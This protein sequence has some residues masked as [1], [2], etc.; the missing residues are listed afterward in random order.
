[1]AAA[2]PPLVIV[3][4]GVAFGCSIGLFSDG[5]TVVIH[6]RRMMIVVFEVIID[7]VF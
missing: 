1:M 2:K 7:V 5:G 4:F 3:I 6:L